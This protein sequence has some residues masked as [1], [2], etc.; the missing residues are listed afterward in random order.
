MS[1]P[2]GGCEEVLSAV[3]VLLANTKGATDIATDEDGMPLDL[4]W[5]AAQC[6][7]KNLAGFIARLRA[8]QGLIETDQ[9]PKANFK[10]VRPFLAM[11]NFSYEILKKKSKPVAFCCAFV[12]AIVAFHDDRAMP[13]EQGRVQDCSTK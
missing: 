6:H 9:V 12:I 3:L 2:P 7:M 8:L 13:S 1:R 11:R 4:L 5:K 10:H